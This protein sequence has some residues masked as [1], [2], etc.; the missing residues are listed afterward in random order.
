MSKCY[1]C[2]MDN[3]KLIYKQEDSLAVDLINCV[4]KADDIQFLSAIRN[5]LC[6]CNHCGLFFLDKRLDAIA[7]SRMY[8]L[9]YEY[10]YRKLMEYPN[11]T[12][13]RLDEFG[14]R[15]F[16][17]ISQYA[18]TKK[19]VLDVGC[20]SGLFLKIC[21]QQGLSC[22][23]IEF[24]DCAAK[25]AINNSDAKVFVGAF[26][27]YKTNEKFDIISMLDYIEHSEEPLEDLKCVYNLLA[28]DGILFL[29]TP[30]INSLQ[31][32]VLKH[33]WYGI[34]SLHLIYFDMQTMRAI[35]DKAG[36]EIISM[37]C[38][39]YTGVL[40]FFHKT[41]QYVVYKF[42]PRKSATNSTFHTDNTVQ[43][44]K[45]SKLAYIKG[46]FM[47]LIDIFGGYIN[48]GNDL[49]VIAKRKR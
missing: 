15:F 3:K 5:Y 37:N 27:N 46:I 22:Y 21:N 12:Q 4:K 43:T 8:Q 18:K 11:Y 42:L 17:A 1:L 13:E 35:L 39:N 45:F 30:N 24:D 49:T 2:E 26:Q 47:Q 19:K 16:P 6:K 36:F 23:G 31:S 25:L 38:K 14:S 29:R 20:G 10:G 41:C 9:W 34:I 48:M 33:K 7:L 40:S 32:K 28:D 44:T